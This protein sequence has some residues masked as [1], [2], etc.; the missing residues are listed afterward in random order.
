MIESIGLPGQAISPSGQTFLASD[1]FLFLHSYEDEKIRFYDFMGNLR[2]APEREGE[3]E[4][5]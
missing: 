2:K 1:F 4:R 3:G 5:E